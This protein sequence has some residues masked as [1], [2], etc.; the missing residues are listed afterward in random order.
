MIIIEKN[1]HYT[2]IIDF[3]AF[4]LFLINT[5]ILWDKAEMIGGKENKGPDLLNAIKR[6]MRL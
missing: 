4:L 3:H 2:E 5:V 6:H 1:Y